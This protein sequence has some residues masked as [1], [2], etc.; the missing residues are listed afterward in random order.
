MVMQCV[1]S[2]EKFVLL[3]QRSWQKPGCCLA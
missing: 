1:L 3:C 2:K